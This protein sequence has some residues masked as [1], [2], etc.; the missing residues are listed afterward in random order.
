[1][2]NDTSQLVYGVN[3][4]SNRP[5]RSVLHFFSKLFYFLLSKVR[6][7]DHSDY[8]HGTPV[9]DFT[10]VPWLWITSSP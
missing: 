3:L 6:S 1:M 8:L 4:Y 5:S 10:D 9:E 7:Q 2:D